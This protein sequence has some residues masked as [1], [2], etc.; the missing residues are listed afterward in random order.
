MY[1]EH[2]RPGTR[3]SR[4]LACS[5]VL[6]AAVVLIDSPVWIDGKA[7]VASSI[8]LGIVVVVH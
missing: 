1:D 3:N 4:R 8:E 7:N 6:L 5:A 2:H